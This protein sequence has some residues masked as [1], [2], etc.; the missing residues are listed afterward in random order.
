MLHC[1]LAESVLL[2]KLLDSCSFIF[3]LL[4]GLI[5]N[6]LICELDISILALLIPESKSAFVKI[7]EDGSTPR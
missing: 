6:D 7:Y 3:A 2:L 1:L 5:R 4:S